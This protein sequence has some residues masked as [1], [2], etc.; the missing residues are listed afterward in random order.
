MASTYDT[1]ATLVHD[2]VTTDQAA[3]TGNAVPAN[4]SNRGLIGCLMLESQTATAVTAIWDVA[5]AN[6]PMTLLKTLQVSTT[7]TLY[8][9]GLLAPTLTGGSQFI[10]FAWTGGAASGA[11]GVV[12]DGVDQGALTT[13]F[14]NFTTATGSS[15]AMS[16]NVS[17]QSNDLTICFGAINSASQTIGAVTGAGEVSIG[18]DNGMSRNECYCGSYMPGA[19]TNT[20]SR[21]LTGSAEWGVIAFDVVA[22]GQVTPQR[23]WI[24]GAR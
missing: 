10:S 21:A 13:T 16:V 11:F 19:A 22:V 23:R 17:S 24:L 3:T 4:V 1:L 12:V 5:S 2:N 9:F 15:A 18:V 7:L 20:M 14:K 8:V 6:Q